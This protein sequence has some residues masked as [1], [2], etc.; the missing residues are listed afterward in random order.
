GIAP[1]ERIRGRDP[2]SSTPQP[3]DDGDWSDP[4]DW[5]SILNAG[6]F[7][8]ESGASR[9]H[10]YPL[11]DDEAT[12][13]CDVDNRMVRGSIDLWEILRTMKELR[14]QFFGLGEPF[15]GAGPAALGIDVP[16]VP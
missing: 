14:G 2:K 7:F 9:E 13:Q 4:I 5:R 12:R 11:R 1:S 16:E 3:E 10:S 15:D 8:L 6:Y